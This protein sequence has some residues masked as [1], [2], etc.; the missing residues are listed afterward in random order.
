MKIALLIVYNHRFDKNIP[1]LEHIYEERF[2]HVFHIVPFYD[3][4]LSNVIPVYDSSYQFQGYI[5]QAYQHLKNMGF[6]HYFVVADDMV[7]HPKINEKNLYQKLGIDSHY[8]YMQS[9]IKFQENKTMWRLDEAL[10]YNPIIKG[11]E[12]KNIIPSKKQ[13]EQKFAEFGIPT[14]KIPSK[15]IK[16]L[17]KLSTLNINNWRKNFENLYILAH[18]RGR[19]LQYPLVGGYSDIF[20]ITADVMPC[21]AQYCGA[22]AATRLFVEIAIPTAM[23]LS[24]AKIKFDKDVALRAL[25]LWSENEKSCLRK[26][27]NSLADLMSDYPKDVLFIHPIKLSKWK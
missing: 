4:T 26:Y 21:F 15:F 13:A 23:I 5:A 6:T 10:K 9:L 20:I 18:N 17:F 25:P 3:G 12:I 8:C 1:T 22:F 24:G 7:I 27:N 11:V 16:G 14:Q 2:S 19:A